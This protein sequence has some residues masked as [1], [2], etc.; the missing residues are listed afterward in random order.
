MRRHD[1]NAGSHVQRHHARRL[2]DELDKNFKQIDNTDYRPSSDRR[3]IGNRR[4]IRS[5]VSITD[6]LN[7]NNLSRNKTISDRLIYLLSLHSAARRMAVKVP[8]AVNEKP[9]HIAAAAAAAATD[10][11]QALAL[12]VTG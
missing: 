11:N 7:D 6:T 10:T 3:R 4:T 9:I 8:S 12:S 5:G 1:G 2:H